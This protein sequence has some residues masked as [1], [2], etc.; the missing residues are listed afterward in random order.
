MAKQTETGGRQGEE[1]VETTRKGVHYDFRF[2]CARRGF[3]VATHRSIAAATSFSLS[4]SLIFSPHF[5]ITVDVSVAYTR[6][7]LLRSHAAES[8]RREYSGDLRHLR[9]PISAVPAVSFLLPD[10]PSAILSESVLPFD[11]FSVY[12]SLSLSLARH[13]QKYQEKERDA[14]LFSDTLLVSVDTR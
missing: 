9:L 13:H 7:K 10:D 2:L 3:A 14:I 8:S 6:V 12:L 5:S 11:H 4:L 1:P